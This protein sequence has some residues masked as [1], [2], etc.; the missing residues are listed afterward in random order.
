[1]A[2]WHMLGGVLIGGC[3]VAALFLISR[4]PDLRIS[5][6]LAGFAATGLLWAA[7]E[8][9]TL[10]SRDIFWEHAGITLLYS[11][12][13]F[14]VP[15]WWG[16]VTRWSASHGVRHRL[17]ERWVWL[18][19]VYAGVFWLLMLTNPWH[20]RFLTPVIGGKNLYEPLWWGITIPNYLLIIAAA[21]V[22]ADACRRIPV[23]AV[24]RQGVAMATASLSVVLANWIFVFGA[25]PAFDATFLV[26]GSA[27]AILVF[28]MYREGLF[29]LLPIAWASLAERDPDG[30][31][32]VGS[33]GKV[34]WANRCAREL[35]GDE[36][37]ADSIF[38]LSILRHLRRPNGAPLGGIGMTDEAWWVE[39]LGPE[40]QVYRSGPEG[41]RWLRMRGHVIHGRSRKMVA[42]CVRIRDV[43]AEREADS[44]LRRADRLES[45]AELAR[46]VAHDFRNLLSLV[47]GNAAL[48]AADLP[49]EPLLQKKVTRILQAGERATELAQQLQLYAGGVDPRSEILDLCAALEELV[50][51]QR[52]ALR[53]G[54]HLGLGS[55]PERLLI[56]ADATQVRQ[57]VMNLLVNACEALGDGPG[58]VRARTGRA[59][60]A[61]ARM[62]HLVLGHDRPEGRYAWVSVADDGP[63]MDAE[64]QERI[65]EPFYSTKGK[66][67]GI[68]LSTVLGIVRAHHAIL[69]LESQPE[70]G[71]AFTVYF[72]L[73]G[74]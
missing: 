40:G 63:G 19:L 60:V 13:I 1:M 68:G 5:R 71:S 23:R 31:V 25:E 38:P 30:L 72:P 48:L 70:R 6:P 24:R 61:P 47:Q 56:E 66:H 37:A 21:G 22:V 58:V 36:L 45:V 39:V 27:G 15:L 52:D 44:E 49:D 43:T 64:T 73:G 62:G 3:V 16:L 7:G 51:L 33:G 34:A 26:L 18:P 28:A 42:L 11:G 74:D 55:Y 14:M 65:F 17:L 4:A 53:P 54:Q 41:E 32:V 67:G 9:I 57:L 20:G 2:T 8:V 10:Y 50:E 59:L 35:L 12:S 69:Q 29:G 46:G